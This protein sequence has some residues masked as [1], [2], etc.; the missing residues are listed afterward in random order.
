MTSIRRMLR[1]LR[2]DILTRHQLIKQY[3]DAIRE[4]QLGC[5]HDLKL[6]LQ[7]PKPIDDGRSP[8]KWWIHRVCTTCDFVT[9]EKYKYPVCPECETELFDYPY[10]DARAEEAALRALHAD[11]H[12]AQIFIF[13]C[14][15]CDVVHGFATRIDEKKK[16]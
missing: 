8:P 1:H 14:A 6:H 2:D 4:V 10:G 5:P 15:P 3:E 12:A 11:K 16:K 13:H 7:Y 9:A